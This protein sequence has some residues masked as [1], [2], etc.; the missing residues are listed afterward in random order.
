MTTQIS[1]AEMAKY[2]LLADMVPTKQELLAVIAEAYKLHMS[3]GPDTHMVAVM[4]DAANP[5]HKEPCDRAYDAIVKD[6]N[7]MKSD[8]TQV[9]QILSSFHHYARPF[10]PFMMCSNGKPLQ[11]I[12]GGAENLLD[13]LHIVLSGAFWEIMLHDAAVAV[14]K[15]SLSKVRAAATEARPLT[16]EYVKAFRGAMARDEAGPPANPVAPTCIDSTQWK[17]LLKAQ[18]AI[19]LAVTGT[20]T[21][22]LAEEPEELAKQVIRY[23]A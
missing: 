19:R 1:A 17:A 10:V 21:G 13:G 14:S 12:G 16:Q 20:A 2:Q 3:S 7:R 4:P 6:L 8:S 18:G 23:K 22:S 15:S 5:A 9:P 11:V